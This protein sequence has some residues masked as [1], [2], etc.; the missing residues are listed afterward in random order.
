MR[1][2]ILS[3]L[4][5]L[6]VGVPSAAAGE[7]QNEAPFSDQPNSTGSAWAAKPIAASKPPAH[8][9]MSAH[10]TSN[11]HGDAYWRSGLSGSTAWTR[12][13]GSGLLRFNNNYSAIHIGPDH[14]LYMGTIGGLLRLED[15]P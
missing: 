8:P 10:S 12:L 5:C 7:L 15:T 4:I 2:A 3:C 9:Y 14:A 11:L 1:H 13:A 6:L